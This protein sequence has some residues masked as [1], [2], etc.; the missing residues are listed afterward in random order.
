MGRGQNLVRGN[1]LT[2]GA[3]DTDVDDEHNYHK[4]VP[5]HDSNRKGKLST[6]P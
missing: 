2:K 5:C 1:R 4:N 6:K 3:G